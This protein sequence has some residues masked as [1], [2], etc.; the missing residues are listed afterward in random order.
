MGHRDVVAQQCWIERPPVAVVAQPH[1]C[2]HRQAPTAQVLA[3]APEVVGPCQ[4]GSPGHAS[5]LRDPDDAAM[6]RVSPAANARVRERAYAAAVAVQGATGRVTITGALVSLAVAGTAAAARPW[7]AEQLRPGLVAAAPPQGCPRPPGASRAAEDPA[8]HP[9]DLPGARRWS[10]P[11]RPRSPCFPRVL[12]RGC[13]PVGGRVG[14]RRFDPLTP[15]PVSWVVVVF[16][17]LGFAALF[18]GSSGPRRT[19]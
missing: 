17:A 1:P 19:T 3:G 5:T 12:P 13:V 9:A 14:T 2:R 4:P 7:P 16:A 8:A 10:W 6:N 11:S 15:G 18:V